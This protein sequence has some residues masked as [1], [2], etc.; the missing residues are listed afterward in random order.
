MFIFFTLLFHTHHHHT[1]FPFPTWPGLA[2]LCSTSGAAAAPC[3]VLC[4]LQQ[5]L[6]V[7]ALRIAYVGVCVREV[8]IV[9]AIAATADA[10]ADLLVAPVLE[11][12]L[13]MLQQHERWEET[14][15]AA[16]A[17]MGG[18]RRRRNRIKGS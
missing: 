1:R 17:V 10:S 9:T 16:A 13:V 14:V 18:R 2:Q 7:L 15:A 3:R 8:I 5:T 11:L 12:L 4:R 6:E